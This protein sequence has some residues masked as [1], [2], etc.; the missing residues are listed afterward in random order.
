MK[1]IL[2]YFWTAILVVIL[3]F[4]MKSFFQRED[5]ATIGQQAETTQTTFMPASFNRLKAPGKYILLTV[6]SEGCNM[7]EL[8][9]QHP[10]FKQL[11][12]TPCFIERE[13]CSNNMLVS[14]ALPTHGFPS[15][16]LFDEQQ[17]LIGYFKGAADI[18]E[19]LNT[20]LLRKDEIPTD[21][22]QMLTYAFKAFIAY[23]NNEPQQM[24]QYAQESMNYQ[25]YFFNH[26]LL[27]IHY[28][29]VHQTDPAEFHKIKALQS[30][31]GSDIFVFETL[32][33]ELSP[34]HPM[35]AW[36]P[37]ATHVHDAD[38]QHEHYVPK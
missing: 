17:N 34:A 11:P 25:S 28:R 21:T 23:L 36:I 33:R 37:E 14:Q 35:L 16:Y 8:I 27:Y 30:L 31:Q 32:V 6:T 26:Y 15:S 9:R 4:C 2:I 10:I 24:Y 22:L 1:K 19:N 38:C 13:F 20:I 29:N 7:C 5:Q 18:E 3:Y 12:L